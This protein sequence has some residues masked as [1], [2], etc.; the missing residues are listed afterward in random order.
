MTVGSKVKG[1]LATL[2][3]TQGTLRIYSIQERNEEAKGVYKEALEVTEK[4]IG[5]L[6]DRIKVLEFEE[7]QYKGN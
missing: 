5:D 1:T 3:G 6:E 7:P 4:I 2:K